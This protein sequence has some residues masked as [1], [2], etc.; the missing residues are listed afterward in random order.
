MHG[1]R[2]WLHFTVG[3]DRKTTMDPLSATA[4]VIAILQLSSEIFKYV[5]TVTDASKDR[6]LLRNEVKACRNILQQLADEADD[7][8][9][10]KAWSET[11][12]TLEAPG[13]PLCRLQ[14]ALDM[15][16]TKLQYTGGLRRSLKWP[17]QEKEVQK[18]VASIER[19]KSLLSLALENNSRKLLQEVTKCS[20]ENRQQLTELVNLVEGHW[21]DQLGHFGDLRN[22]MSSILHRVDSLRERQDTQQTSEAHREVLEWLTAIDFTSQQHDYLAR[23]QADTGQWLI[24]SDI[25]Q[26]WIKAEKK[27]LFCPGIPGAG[28]T[29]LTSI[30]VDD[31]CER[32]RDDPTVGLAYIYCNFRRQEEQNIPGLMASLLKQLTAG[33][34]AIPQIV[35]DLYNRHTKKRTRPSPEKIFKALQSVIESYSIV[36]ILVD[37][38]DECEQVCRTRLLSELF[39]LQRSHVVQFLATS[40]HIPEIT[41]RF[42]GS[43]VLEILASDEDVAKY[44]K[45]QMTRLPGFVQRN[46]KLRQDIE[47]Q[48]V[49]T[50]QGMYV[51]EVH[52]AKLH[53]EKSIGFYWPSSTSTH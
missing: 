19:E 23:R 47:D 29:I 27:T 18:I 14:V 3:L 36:F 34:H 15:M 30:I 39:N 12:K 10:G 35:K 41:E 13:G 52:V 42:K 20:K 38:L 49:G 33:K 2:P 5:N 11:I 43:E 21:Q 40:R 44:L 25:Y 51:N 17:F 9:E 22:D 8:V 48:I 53:A 26:R 6:D 45:G 4:S 37:A 7:S 24:E 32:Y 50:V 46:V 31:I 1:L 16:K 28:K